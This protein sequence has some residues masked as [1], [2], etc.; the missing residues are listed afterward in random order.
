MSREETDLEDRLP[1][2]RRSL[3][4]S[5]ASLLLI[6]LL[7]ALTMRGGTSEAGMRWFV[8]YVVAICVLFLVLTRTRVKRLSRFPGG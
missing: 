6:G 7:I 5:Y 2:W 8:D 4:Q 1:E 3:H